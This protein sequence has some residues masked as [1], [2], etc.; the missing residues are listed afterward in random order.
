MTDSLSGDTTII[1]LLPFRHCRDLQHHT[2]DYFIR[3]FDVVR[4]CDIASTDDFKVISN[5]DQRV[6]FHDGNRPSFC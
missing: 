2:L 3:I 6:A 4:R 1:V 5:G